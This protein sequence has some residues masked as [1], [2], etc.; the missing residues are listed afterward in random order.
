M[1]CCLLS[2][3]CLNA[4]LWIVRKNGMASASKPNL[5]LALSLASVVAFL[6]KLMKPISS[7]LTPFASKDSTMFMSVV[8]LPVP[9]GPK[10]MLGLDEVATAEVRCLMT[11]VLE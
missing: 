5:D 1:T 6:V 10:M 4:K 3:S 2:P 7:G 11:F 9:G 8:V